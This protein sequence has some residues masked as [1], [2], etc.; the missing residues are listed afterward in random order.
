MRAGKESALRRVQPGR[1]YP[2]FPR[3]SDAGYFP[4]WEFRIKSE[5]N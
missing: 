5:K 1:L 2:A 4:M 3:H